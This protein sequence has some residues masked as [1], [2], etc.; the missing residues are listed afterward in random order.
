MKAE[1]VLQTIGNTPHIRLA[2]LFPQAE[3]WVKSERSNPGGSIK[4]R[5]AP[6]SYTHL[7]AHET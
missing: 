7:R 2:R 4:D 3:V 1:N 6:V 5:I